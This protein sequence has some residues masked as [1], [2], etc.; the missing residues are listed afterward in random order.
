MV[1]LRVTK[2]KGGNF[3]DLKSAL[4]GVEALEACDIYC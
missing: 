2:I 1:D 4:D 3:L